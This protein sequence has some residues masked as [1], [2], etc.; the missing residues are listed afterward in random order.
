MRLLSF[1]LNELHPVRLLSFILNE[2]HPVRLLSFILNELCSRFVMAV[3]FI[4]PTVCRSSCREFRRMR[5]FYYDF[6]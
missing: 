2:L 3:A 5:F 4:L 6:A 1:I